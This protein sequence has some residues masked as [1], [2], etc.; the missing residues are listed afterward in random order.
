MLVFIPEDKF[1]KIFFIFSYNEFANLFPAFDKLINFF[2]I[3]Y[4]FVDA[5]S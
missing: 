4:I 3:S 5:S 2:N 1:G